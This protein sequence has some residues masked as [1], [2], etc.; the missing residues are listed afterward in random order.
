M[1]VNET[2]LKPKKG[3][4]PAAPRS[5]KCS[6]EARVAW[7]SLGKEPGGGLCE[8]LLGGPA[9]QMYATTNTI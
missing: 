2:S 3:A 4:A 7:C 8:I 5:L 1:L 6:W 9:D